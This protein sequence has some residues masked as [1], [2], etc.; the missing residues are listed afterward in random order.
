VNAYL[1]AVLAAA[2]VLFGLGSAT[3]RT[4]D[5]SSYP[6]ASVRWLDRQGLLDEPHRLAAQDVVGCYL[7]LRDGRR[8]RVFI[9]D[10]VDMYPVRVTEDYV[11]LLHGEPDAL[12]VLQRRRVDVVL[13]DAQLPLATIL[14]ASPKWRQA[15]RQGGWVVFVR[16]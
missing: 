11:A 1:G 8:A 16:K 7:V 12:S 3:G 4:V 13:W 6:V 10:R 2:V 14:G 5:L 9:D 15:H